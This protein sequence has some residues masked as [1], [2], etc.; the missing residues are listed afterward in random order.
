MRNTCSRRTSRIFG[1]QTTTEI[2]RVFTCE[3][4]SMGLKPRMNTT[5]PFSIGGTNVAIACPNMWLSGSRLRNRIGANGRL[6]L[7]YFSTS[8]STGT[9]FARTLRCVMTT[10]LGSAVAPEVK[11]ISAT[12]SR[13]MLTAGIAGGPASGH[14]R[15]CSAQSGGTDVSDVSGEARSGG[16]SCPTSTSLAETIRLTRS[17]KSGDER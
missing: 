11:M 6:H 4:M 13:V 9:M 7:R 17:R 12:S 2:R 5:T 14:S 1:T 3:T 16:T 10:P 15:S 8:R